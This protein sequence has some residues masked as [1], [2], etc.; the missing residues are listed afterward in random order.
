MFAPSDH[1]KS[2]VGPIV[3]SQV[4]ETHFVSAGHRCGIARGNQKA[5]T[6]NVDTL[7]P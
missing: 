7:A 1:L 4:A 5:V 6:S 3:E 2:V